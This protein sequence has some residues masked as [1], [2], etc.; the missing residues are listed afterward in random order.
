MEVNVLDYKEA[1]MPTNVNAN[2]VSKESIA[3]LVSPIKL[4]LSSVINHVNAR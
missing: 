2:L 1:A 4:T 3:K